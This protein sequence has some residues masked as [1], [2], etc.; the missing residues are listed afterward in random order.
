[1]KSIS[2]LQRLSGVLALFGWCLGAVAGPASAE[3]ATN[4]LLYVVGDSHLDTQWNWTVQDTIHPYLSNTLVR[5]FV[6]FTNY[7]DYTFSF[8]G[9]FKYQLA[10]EYYPAEYE[11]LKHYIAQ[12]RWRV[13]GASV[14]AGDVNIP[15]PES[16]IRH[17]LYGN[18]YFKQEFGKTSLDLF[19]PD[20]FGFSYALPSI[21]AHCGLKGFSSAKLLWGSAIPYPFENIGRWVGPDGASVV[22]VI[23]PGA[24]DSHITENLANATNYLARID[25][26]GKATG[27]YLDYRYFGTGDIGGAPDARSVD[28]LEQSIHTTN[29]LLRVESAGADQL[30]RDLTPEQVVKLPTYQGELLMRIH[31]VGCYTAHSEM[32]TFNRRNEHWADSA[33]RAAV[34]ADWLQ[35]GGTYPQ[36]RLT[37]AWERFLWHQ[38]HDD[39][40]GTS[41]DAAYQFSWNDELL[42]LNEFAAEQTRG[43]GV[44]A[45]ALDTTATGVP[46]VVFNPLSVES[47]DLVEATVTFSNGLPRA[48]R[49]FGPDGKEV[50]AQA[51]TPRGH[52]LPIV[53]LARVPA[54][55]AATF[56][57]RPADRPCALKT[58]LAVSK[59][60]LENA[61]YRVRLDGN[62]D[63]R[64][65]YDKANQQELLARPIRWAFLHDEGTIWPAWEITYASE[66]GRPAYLGR[67]ARVEVLESGP[68]RVT[69]GITRFKDNSTFLERISLAAGEAGDRV[70]WDVSANWHTRG[71]LLKVEFPLTAANPKATFD[72]GLG[73]IER[74]NATPNLYEVPAQQWADLTDTNGQYGVTVLNDSKYGWDKPDDHT[75]RLTI[76]HTPTPGL[77]YPHGAHNSLGSHRFQFAVMGHAGDWR[78]GRSSWTAARLNQPLQAF[79][80]A[81]H[82][83]PLGKTFAFLTTDSPNVMVKA[84]KKAEASDE[85]VVRLQE[86]TG[87]PQTVQLAGAAPIVAA[88]ELTGAEEPLG[89]LTPAGGKLTLKLTP[90]QPRTLALTL[91]AAAA[92]VPKVVSQP[93]SLPFNLDVFSRDA[94]RADG[95]FYQGYTIPAELVPASVVRD[96]VNFMLGSTADGAKN[97]VACRGQTIALPGSGFTRLYLLAA[98]AGGDTP[99]VFAVDGQARRLTVQDFTGF[100]GQWKPP[101]VKPDEVAWVFTH[102]H[103]RDGNDPYRFCYLFKYSL[104]L[105]ANARTLTLPDAPNVRVFAVSLAKGTAEETQPAGG[106]LAANELPWASAGANQIVNADAHGVAAVTLDGTGCGDPDGKIVSYLWTMDEKPLAAGERAV[107]KLKLGRHLI[108]LAVT[109][110]AG[111]TSESEVEVQ[112]LP[113]LQVTVKASA[114]QAAAAPLTVQFAATV[115]GGRTERSHALTLD[116]GGTMTAQGE[117]APRERVQDAFDGS[118]ATKWLDFALEDPATRA[119]W[120]QYEFPNG[121]RGEVVSYSLTAAADA[122][123]RDPRDW[124]LLGSNDAGA[125][126]TTLDVQ[127]NQTFAG[128]GLEKAFRLAR[129]ASF[130]LFRLQIDCVADPAA[131]NAV[132]LAELKLIGTPADSYVW[133]FGD[134]GHSREQSPQHTYAHEGNYQVRLAAARGDYTGTHQMLM[135]VGPPLRATA[136]ATPVAGQPGTVAF[137]ARASGGN[138][139]RAPYNTTLDG[140]GV[141]AA[142]GENQPAEIAANAFDATSATKWLDFA[143]ENPATRASWIQY[144]YAHG[145]QYQVGRYALTSANDE[146]GRDPMNWRLLG[147]NDGGATWTIVDVRTN[148]TFTDRNQR[149]EFSCRNAAGF[150]LYR[151][152]IDTVKDAG[153]GGALQLAD[154]ELIGVPLYRYEWDFG[155][156]FMSTEPNPQHTYSDS[157]RHDVSLVVSDGAAS[158][159]NKLTVIPKP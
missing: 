135:T 54:V 52:S 75:L 32:K 125:N 150:R 2:S 61:R 123:A 7:P 47:E 76:F 152:E 158:V 136:T 60:R 3:P 146:P 29:G 84:V 79:A 97:A 94:N 36:E 65:I 17:A 38:F 107:V 11:T 82:P 156:G 63:V 80:A 106:P 73:T 129:P 126:W 68:A 95:D 147:S 137:A 44:L 53:F 101:L 104:D 110:N 130:N 145:Q 114:T 10:K 149:R 46:L 111:A 14:D 26:M 66:T 88:R 144:A 109:D 133:Q 122:P 57:V 15:S 27:L 8:E 92:T 112:V 13:A 42:S 78:A 140:Y 96:G 86:L 85:V 116:D 141:V 93:V 25:E 21:A 87:R 121:R 16:L 20:C 34:M 70:G 118:A 67:P 83:G 131:A 119:S 99:A 28:W 159:T 1:M 12:G 59:S 6:L 124:R 89:A 33:E 155:D 39:L 98:A 69:L 45:R 50:P 77:A 105:P 72:L 71:T 5:N 108:R 74:G 40:T 102:R 30:Y 100:I 48:V 120:I 142:Q 18:G 91:G 134:G 41:I 56:D 113:S 31:G 139:A 49:V 127:T 154:L 55:G 24:Y 132:Q 35:G 103:T 138:A 43:I 148:E 22:A 90:Y 23:Q 151:L 4:K 143:G 37:K 62:G 115:R 81:A 58:G 9:A 19:L 153:A 51:G 64:S 117:H 128:R 157:S